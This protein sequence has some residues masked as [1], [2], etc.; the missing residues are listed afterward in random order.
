MTLTSFFFLI[1][2]LK[3]IVYQSFNLSHIYGQHFRKKQLFNKCLKSF[4]ATSLFL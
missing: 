2:D 4:Q 3:M 1:F